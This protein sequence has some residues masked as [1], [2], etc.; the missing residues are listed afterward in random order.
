MVIYICPTGVLF[1]S[2]YH[3]S[4]RQLFFLISVEV[5]NLCNSC[6]SVIAFS[7]NDELFVQC[8]ICCIYTSD[9]L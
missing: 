9:N 2:L 8:M 5:N 4:Q 6:T 3:R 1:E 7:S